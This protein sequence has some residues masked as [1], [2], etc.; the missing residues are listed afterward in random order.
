MSEIDSNWRIKK[1]SIFGS[2]NDLPIKLY[3]IEVAPRL[4][5]FEVEINPE[6]NGKGIDLRAKHDHAIGIEVERGWWI[7]DFWKDM[8]YSL[9]AKN[10]KFQTLNMPRRKERYYWEFYYYKD[11]EGNLIRV[12][13][14]DKMNKVI[15][16]RFNWDGSQ[17]NIV[18]ADVVHN[19]EKLFRD[20]FSTY[21]TEDDEDEDWLC[22]KKEDVVT[23][24][25]QI[26]G[27][28][29]RDTDQGGEYVP[30]SQEE[31]EKQK[32][33]IEAE[34]E[35]IKEERMRKAKERIK[36]VMANKK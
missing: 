18:Y 24:N 30:L 8:Y 19:P 14:K 3:V 33:E 29:V 10:L 32:K 23:L 9:M 11:D 22:F 12:E 17:A 36:E 1:H 7:G 34:N 4:L 21:K 28:F 6:S 13:N 15:F 26:D 2:F 20:R 35:R 27:N 31:I 5:G 16:I 25:K